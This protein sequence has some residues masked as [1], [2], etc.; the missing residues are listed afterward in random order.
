MSWLRVRKIPLVVSSF[1]LSIYQAISLILASSGPL[2]GVLADAMGL[3]F[4]EY[5]P[6]IPQSINHKKERFPEKIES[7]FFLVKPD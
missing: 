3:G 4:S 6:R 7:I 1:L 2:S 5:F